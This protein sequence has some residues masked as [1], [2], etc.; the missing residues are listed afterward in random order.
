MSQ[1]LVDMR[2]SK[3]ERKRLNEAAVASDEPAIPYGLSITLDDESLDKLGFKKLPAVGDRMVVAA[4]GKVESV[5]ERTDTRETDRDV[6]IQL[7]RLDVS[8]V[9]ARKVK[10]AEDAVSEAIKDV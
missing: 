1:H 3:K 2:R 9:P 8:P 5:S 6:R 7:E 10:T 4:I